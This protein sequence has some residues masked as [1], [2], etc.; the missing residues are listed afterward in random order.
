MKISVNA[1]YILRAMCELGA[2]KTETPISISK[3][4][5]NQH[6]PK[7]YL[8]KLF[9]KLKKAGLVKSILGKNGGYILADIPKNITMKRIFKIAENEVRIHNCV[10]IKKDKICDLFGDCTFKKFWTDFDN[11]IN[12]FLDS[13]TLADFIFADNSKNN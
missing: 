4:A 3:I 8:E 13:H 12:F 2:D 11:H 9:H 6:I 7:K 5:E 1:D 10:N